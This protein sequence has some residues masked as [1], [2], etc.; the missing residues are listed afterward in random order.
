MLEFLGVVLTLVFFSSLLVGIVSLVMRRR[1]KRFFLTSLV[2]FALLVV[3]ASIGSSTQPAETEVQTAEEETYE[4][5]PV[6]KEDSTSITEETEITSG[7]VDTASFEAYAT[8]LTGGTFIQTTD[9]VEGSRAV[10][11]YVDSFDQYTTNKPNSSV[12]EDSYNSYFSS[13][14]AIEKIM[15]GEPARLLKEFD[16]LESVSLTLPFRG[17]TYTTDI[18]KEELNDYLGFNIDELNDD[19]WRI[20]FSDKYIYN[21]TERN[22]AFRRFVRVQ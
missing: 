1:V 22:A 5:E 14:D 21:Q 13:G 9:L 7:E 2:S 3:V 12:T 8:N 4:T 16:G 6:V 15:V 19:T 17:K 10:I 20:N 11:K 18:T